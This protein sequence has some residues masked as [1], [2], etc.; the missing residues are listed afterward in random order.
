VACL[1]VAQR[2]MA[3][4]L[5]QRRHDP[6]RA[7]GA[8]RRWSRLSMEAAALP[9]ESHDPPETRNRP[10][11]NAEFGAPA[12]K[13]VVHTDPVCDRAMQGG[14]KSHVFQ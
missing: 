11:T 1:T 8:R 4:A 3:L 9:V 10:V 12:H 7:I 6:R 5:A 14:P 2:N 13:A